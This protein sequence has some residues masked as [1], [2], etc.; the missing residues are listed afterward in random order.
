LGRTLCAS[1]SSAYTPPSSSPSSSMTRRL[2][3]SGVIDAQAHFPSYH[4]LL[5]F[6]NCIQT[7]KKARCRRL[8]RRQTNV[9]F[10]RTS[11]THSL[12]SEAPTDASFA[13]TDAASTADCTTPV[14]MPF[15]YE[16]AP[17]DASFAVTDAVSTADCTTPVS[18]PFYYEA[19]PTDKKSEDSDVVPSLLECVMCFERKINCVFDCGHVSCFQC[20]QLI[21]DCHICRKTIVNRIKLYL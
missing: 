8:M 18:M 6:V 13:V 10:P 21:T 17:T 20:A 19:S 2:V 9:H 5:D 12:P 15:Y 7:N 4:Y 11:S 1:Y 16:E 3:S 14:S